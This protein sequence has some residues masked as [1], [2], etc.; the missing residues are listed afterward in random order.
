MI[1]L[2]FGDTDLPLK[3]LE[4]LKKKD[5]KYVIIDITKSK[6]FKKHIN[7]HPISI[8]QFGKII[9]TLKDKRVKRVLFAGKIQKPKF[10]SL[11]M[12]LKGFYYLPSIIKAAKLGDAA[13][14]KVIIKILNKEKIKVISSIAYNPELALSKGIYTKLK[15][16]K[17]QNS[18]IIKGIK[19]FGK[20]NPHNHTQGIIIKENNIIAKETSK[21]T[22]RML[23]LLSKYKKTNSI[24]IK[25]PK[26]NQDFRIDL[27]TIGL[28]TVKDCKKAGIKG[29]VLKA[30]KNIFMDRIKSITYANKNKIFITVK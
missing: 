22:K 18:S 12:D 5:V 17:E 23:Q 14:L 28:D 4:K 8:G 2:I 13:I 30:K 11:K 25:F 21:G 20:L 9:K 3:I 15:P 6:K 16:S 1:G 10:S 7:A 24:L 29:I 27:P 26:K 19:L